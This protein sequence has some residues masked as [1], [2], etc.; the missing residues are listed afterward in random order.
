MKTACVPWVVCVTYA[1]SQSAKP[2]DLRTL[3]LFAIGQDTEHRLFVETEM[4][5]SLMAVQAHVP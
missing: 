1:S 3:P 2:A 4:S 5:L